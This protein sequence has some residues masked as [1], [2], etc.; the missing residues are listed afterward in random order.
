MRFGPGGRTGLF[1]SRSLGSQ[2]WTGPSPLLLAN[3]RPSGLQAQA[4]AFARR[5]DHFLTQSD[6]SEL[7]PAASVP[8]ADGPFGTKGCQTLPIRP[9]GDGKNPLVVPHQL[10]PDA[11]VRKADQVG[12]NVRLSAGVQPRRMGTSD[13]QEAAIRAHGDGLRLCA[14]RQGDGLELRPA[15]LIQ[16]EPLPAAAVRAPGLGAALVQKSCAVAESKRRRALSAWPIRAV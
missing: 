11:A 6:G 8:D 12:W 4:Q 2:T 1:P 13:R 10:V 14:G 7:P 9:K 15:P 5:R 3:L 16:V